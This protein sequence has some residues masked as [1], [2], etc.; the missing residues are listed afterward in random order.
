MSTGNTIMLTCNISMSTSELIVTVTL[1][2]VYLLIL[3]VE[4]NKSSVNITVLPVAMKYFTHR[5]QNHATIG[6]LSM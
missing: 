3:H 4:M 6:F 1:V 5:G 2:R